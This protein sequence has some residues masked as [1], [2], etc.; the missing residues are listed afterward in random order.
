MVGS[1]RRESGDGILGEN[2]RRKAKI[3]EH[4]RRSIGT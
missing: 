1:L 4:W 2:T 3:Q